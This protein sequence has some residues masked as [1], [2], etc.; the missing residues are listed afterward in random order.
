MFCHDATRFVLFL[1]GLRKAQFNELGSKGFRELYTATLAMAGC[2]HAQLR[3]AELA[4]GE[5]RFDTA[6]DRSVQGS[7]RI[8]KQDLE[9][10]VSRAPNVLDVDPAAAACWLNKRPARMRDD[11]VWPDRAMREAVAAL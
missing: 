6:S 2:T 8:A 10:Y 5:V 1:P 9:A 4:L 7:L 3:K 11:L